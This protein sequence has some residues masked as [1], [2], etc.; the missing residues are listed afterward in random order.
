MYKSF[1]SHKNL[2]FDVKLLHQSTA[3]WSYTSEPR[4]M[5]IS[6]RREHTPAMSILVLRY[7]DVYIFPS[8]RILPER[9]ERRVVREPLT[10]PWWKETWDILWCSL[11]CLFPPCDSQSSRLSWTARPQNLCF[12]WTLHSHRKFKKY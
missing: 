1:G 12:Y 7:S 5:V 2:W 11:W 6:K 3:T 10:H 9:H 4:S 8:T